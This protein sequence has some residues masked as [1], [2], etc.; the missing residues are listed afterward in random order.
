MTL[1]NQHDEDRDQVFEA[2]NRIIKH[3]IA[4]QREELDRAETERDRALALIADL[5]IGLEAGR[6]AARTCKELTTALRE[7][8]L[9]LDACGVPEASSIAQRV[10]LLADRSAKTVDSTDSL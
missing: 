5:E 6:R 10:R 3:F 8:E 9:V 4:L 1:K 2:Q 7:I